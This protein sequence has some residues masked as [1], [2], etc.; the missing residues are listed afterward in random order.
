MKK[1][2]TTAIVIS[3]FLGAFSLHAEG[4]SPWT[5][6]EVLAMTQPSTVDVATRNK[7][8]VP[9]DPAE[10]YAGFVSRLGT[11]LPSDSYKWWNFDNANRAEAQDAYITIGQESNKV[12]PIW[13]GNL[14]SY[15]YGTTNQEFLDAVYR[16]INYNRRLYLGK[17]VRYIY[18]DSRFQ[19]LT[20]AA[21]M[22]HFLNPGKSAHVIDSSY[23]GYSDLAKQGCYNSDLGS[24]NTPSVFSWDYYIVDIGNSDPGHR[25]WQ[26]NQFATSIAIGTCYPTSNRFSDATW[27]DYPSAFAYHVNERDPIKQPFF[28]PYPG[29]VPCTMLSPSSYDN[30]ILRFSISFE[31]GNAHVSTKPTI[32]VKRDGEVL[33]VLAI[34]QC[35]DSDFWFTINV[36]NM[37]PDSFGED[38]RFEVTFDNVKFV[39]YTAPQDSEDDW[40]IA[41]EAL[42]PRT[43]SYSF[44]VYNPNKNKSAA[45]ST[46]STILGLS[47]RARIGQGDDVL[48]GGLF[49]S[50][51]E[52]M[53]VMLRA[54]GPSLA[55]G[56]ITDYAK[57]PKF[58]LHQVGG[59]TVALGTVDN[60]KDAQNWRM[61]EGYGFAPADANDAA[62]IATLAPGLYTITVSDLGT[63]GVGIVE[64]YAVD[65]QSASQLSGVST[66]GI[67]DSGVDAMV[68]G[69]IIQKS[70]TVVVTAKGP[71]LSAM[72]VSG[73]VADTKLRIVGSDGNDVAS[74]D[75]W[76]VAAN[77]RLKT[78]LAGYA[79][80]NAKESAL[81]ITLPAGAY[82]VVCESKTGKGVGIV[83]VYR[84]E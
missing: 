19:A 84:V 13:T 75:D 83:E 76:D 39:G 17:Y 29:Y 14:A 15:D 24:T 59:Q 35:G 57:N 44:T 33:P 37:S 79:P 43:L 63:G 49:V 21:A 70:Q 64:A 52:P 66:R 80:L 41:L 62:A 9:S 74:N 46:K 67:M 78:D 54:Q 2:Y 61:V 60:W 12:T 11:W 81:V 38:Q 48:I 34:G 55:A 45:W 32:T 20:Q 69:L 77:A 6:A 30:G 73:A 7:G 3:A 50:G 10:R 58:E 16:Y 68:A 8:V 25:L 31:S 71:S 72:G 23:A 18:E 82:T 47:T 5:D 22:V 65:A 26:L 36:G 4:N 56:G 1:H 27:V 51:S 53:R 28:Y 40:W 42:L